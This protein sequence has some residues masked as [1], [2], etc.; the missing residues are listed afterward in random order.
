MT[1]KNFQYR[2]IP[3]L[4]LTPTDIDQTTVNGAALGKWWRQARQISFIATAKTLAA[5]T[6]L[7]IKVQGLLASDGTTWE[8]L[9][10]FDGTTDLSMS[11]TEFN[12]TGEIEG[13]VVMGTMS[14]RFVDPT[15]YE[16]F[17]ITVTEAGGAATA[18]CVIAVLSD[19]YEMYTDAVDYLFDQQVKA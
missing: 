9:K 18:V 15:V 5:S 12:D 13:G 7:T 8:N 14:S 2:N 16:D 19:L 17:R 10:G 6:T 1:A 4:A 3:K 11:G